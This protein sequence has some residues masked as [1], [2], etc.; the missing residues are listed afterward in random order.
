[1]LRTSLPLSSLSCRRFAPPRLFL[2]FPVGASRLPASCF[3]LAGCHPGRGPYLLSWG[4]DKEEVTMADKVADF[5]G[6]PWTVQAVEKLRQL[7]RE[8]VPV[9][10]IS[11]T[12][13][14]SEAEIRAK[15]AELALPQHLEAS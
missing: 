6:A 10:L 3:D 5:T 11:Q 2:H 15:A 14:R 12:L 13:G 4:V 9:P 7:W 1:V 8:A